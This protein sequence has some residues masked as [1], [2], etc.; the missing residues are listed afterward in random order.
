[1]ADAGHD[2]LFLA[3]AVDDRGVLLVNPNAL[4][5]TKYSER[6]ILE[7]DAKVFRD[8][9]AA[10][11]DGDVFKHG[12][13]AIAEARRL[14]GRDLEAAAQLVDDGRRQRLALNVLGDDEPWL[15]V[16]TIRTVF[17]FTELRRLGFVPDRNQLMEVS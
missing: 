4:G 1:M 7:L 9:L 17:S 12:L 6:H 10:R 8:Q 13:A 16:A 14:D 2:V 5:A 11:E 3:R 15:M